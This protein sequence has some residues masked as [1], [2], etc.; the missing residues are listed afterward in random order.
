MLSIYTKSKPSL[1]I[2]PRGNSACTQPCWWHRVVNH[3]D[4]STLAVEHWSSMYHKDDWKC[5]ESGSLQLLPVPTGCRSGA[6]AQ[7]AQL[8]RKTQ[9]LKVR[10]RSWL[11]KKL[12]RHIT[13]CICV[14]VF[15]LYYDLGRLEASLSELSQG[16]SSA[17]SDL[18]AQV[19][20]LEAR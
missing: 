1:I 19:K 18:N 7:S 16:H 13:A 20:L 8:S 3:C 4:D 5:R 6:V 17:M 12:Q 9:R 15:Q 2:H 10:S 14:F 11:H